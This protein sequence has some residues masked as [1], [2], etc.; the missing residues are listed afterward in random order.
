MIKLDLKAEL[1]PFYAPS[2]K[3][4]ELIDVPRFQFVMIDG[5]I[6]PGQGPGTSPGFKEAMGALYGAS[7]TLK[8]MCKQRKTDPVD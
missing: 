3:K 1:K 5:R 4:V 2:A 6:E 8:F 7:Y